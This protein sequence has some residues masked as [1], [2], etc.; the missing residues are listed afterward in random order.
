MHYQIKNGKL[1]KGRTANELR[2]L[3]EWVRLLAEG[4]FEKLLGGIGI[5]GLKNSVGLDR[6]KG[7]E[8]EHSR[9]EQQEYY[10]VHRIDIVDRTKGT[11]MMLLLQCLGQL[12]ESN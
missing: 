8:E 10:T 11:V 9:R 12:L 2:S 4:N 6:G 3:E 1:P 7:L 5:L